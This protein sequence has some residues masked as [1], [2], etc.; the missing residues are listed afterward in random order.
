LGQWLT[1][2]VSKKIS[3]KK[4]HRGSR[5]RILDLA[6]KNAEFHA[7]EQYRKL[8][9]AKRRIAE[10]VLRLGADLGL[11]PLPLRIEGFDISHHGGE[12]PVASMVVF[13]NGQPKKSDYRKFKI[14]TAPGGD[15]FRSMEEVI[16][17]RFAH[18]EPEFGPLPDLVLIDG[19][20]VQLEFARK[21]IHSVASTQQEPLRSRLQSQP[22]ISLAKREEEIFLPDN[23]A[24]VR[25]RERHPGLKLLQ[26]VRDESHRFAVT[27]HRQRKGIKR[28]TSIL[29]TIPGIG[30]K[31]MEA[32][33]TRFGSV[34][35]IGKASLQE[36]E[37]I[38]GL[39]S[40]L[41]LKISEVC[42]NPAL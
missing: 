35:G 18:T 13:E 38:T 33:L 41:A 24:P 10:S 20:P 8:H 26:Q 9:G 12:E 23:P 22:M 37:S 6:A 3:V 27:F 7:A 31:R 19:G 14:K 30:P 29:E 1:G 15:D 32:L 17:R 25:L 21:A 34:E 4:P 2:M 39:N 5:M 28:Q 42:R 40:G 11:N 36:I 16:G